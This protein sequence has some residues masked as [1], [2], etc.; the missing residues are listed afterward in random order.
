MVHGML[1]LLS[2]SRYCS[3]T[4]RWRVGVSRVGCFGFGFGFHRTA[5]VDIDVEP[6]SEHVLMLKLNAPSPSSTP[7]VQLSY[8]S[9]LHPRKL[10]WITQR[11]YAQYD[12]DLPSESEGW[13]CTCILIIINFRRAKPLVHRPWT[14]PHQAEPVRIRGHQR[15]LQFQDQARWFMYDYSGNGVLVV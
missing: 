11:G 15:E 6:V 9:S 2:S 8:D 3:T 5:R 12:I 14:F 7:H 1:V 4:Q 10:P 13:V